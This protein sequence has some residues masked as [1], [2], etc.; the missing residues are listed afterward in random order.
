MMRK[1]VSNTM[2]NAFDAVVAYWVVVVSTEEGTQLPF[3]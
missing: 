1:V 3:N 2:E